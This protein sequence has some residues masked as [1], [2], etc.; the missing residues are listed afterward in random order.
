MQVT[1]I[2]EKL[3]QQ[4]LD[5]WLFYDFRRT[6]P[7]A[8]RML[9]LPDELIVTRRWYY[10]VPR[11]GAPAGLVSALEAHNLDSLPGKKL[12]Y[13]TWQ[14]RTEALRSILPLGGRVAMEYSPLNAIPYVALVD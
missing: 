11:T 6:N 12:V 13:R 5:G 9:E 10:F 8:Y 1:A 2:Q 14:D 4:G 3:N 7:I